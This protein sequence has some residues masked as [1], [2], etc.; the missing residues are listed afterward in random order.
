M[1]NY[2][3]VRM[4]RAGA[5]EMSCIAGVGGDVAPLVRTAKSG[6]PIIALDGCA[7]HCTAHILK[8][9]NLAPALYVNLGDRG[10]KKRKHEDFSM[11]EADALLPTLLQE[12]VAAMT[13][14][15]A[16]APQTQTQP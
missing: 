14:A 7:L 12:A 4:D 1:A 11:D 9:H 3:A 6:R 8:R 10:V 5:A 16:P 13:A 2:L 15:A